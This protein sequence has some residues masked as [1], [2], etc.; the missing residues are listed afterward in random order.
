M[1]PTLRQEVE[2]YL[3]EHGPGNPSEIA[4][5]IRARRDD[6]DEILTGDGFCRVPHP[7][8]VYPR[9]AYFDL[10]QAVP[11]AAE[12]APATSATSDKAFL[13]RVL[14]DGRWHSLPEILNRSVAERGYGLTVHS[15]AADLRRDGHVIE[16][17][18]KRSLGRRIVSFY[19]LAGRARIEPVAATG[20]PSSANEPLPLEAA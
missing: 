5:A 10:S 4:M 16:N 7:E 8:G 6:V 1:R 12:A 2:A 17:R 14:S 19:R 18:T 11:R 9:A 20:S 3:R 13:L 15:R